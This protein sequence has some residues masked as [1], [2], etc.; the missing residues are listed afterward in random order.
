MIVFVMVLEIQRIWNEII[1]NIED[2][3]KTSKGQD[4]HDSSC[5]FRWLALLQINE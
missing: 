2:P 1:Y 5:Q 4:Q 3:I